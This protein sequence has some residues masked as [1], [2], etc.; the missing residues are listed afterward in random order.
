MT[1]RGY[2]TDLIESICEQIA[3]SS[4][5]REMMDDG[6]SVEELYKKS[7]V[8]RRKG[9]ESLLYLTEN[10]NPKYHCATKHSLG[11]WW[12]AVE[13]YEASGDEKDYEYAKELGNLAAECLSGYLGWHEDGKPA[14]CLRCLFDLAMVKQYEKEK[15]AKIE[16]TKENND[17][18]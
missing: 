18:E 17:N 15:S 13:V 14:N 5:L 1:N 3:L 16:L 10:P 11:A 6:E 8:L 2:L 12:R 7:L 9:M 4:H